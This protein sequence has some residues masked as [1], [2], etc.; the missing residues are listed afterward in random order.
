MG[1]RVGGGSSL[2]VGACRSWVVVGASLWWAFAW[3]EGRR[4]PWALVVHGSW[5]GHRRGGQGVALRGGVVV[6]VRLWVVL[7]VAIEQWWWWLPFVVVVVLNRS[8][9]SWFGCR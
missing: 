1:V 6:R 4:C 8:W 2:P 7:V 5:L 3:V 9:L